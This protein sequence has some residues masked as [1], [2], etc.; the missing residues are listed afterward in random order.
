MKFVKTVVISLLLL[1]VFSGCKE[2]SWK[3]YINNN[4]EKVAR[5]VFY[6]NT[7]LL[8]KNTMEIT[9]NPNETAFFG[10]CF[11]KSDCYSLFSWIHVKV[12]WGDELAY[13][14]VPEEN[15]LH[16]SSILS[17][18]YYA[19]IDKEVKYSE[20]V[21]DLFRWC[22]DVLCENQ[23]YRDPPETDDDVFSGDS[24][25]LLWSSVARAH[26]TRKSALRYCEDLDEA[27]FQDWRL[28]SISELRTLIQNCPYMEY[29]KPAGLKDNE[30]CGVTDSCLMPDE[31]CD[32]A[33]RSCPYD[34][35]TP[36][37]Y[38]KFGDTEIFWTSSTP[39]ESS[40]SGD[41]GW[42]LGF[43]PP[44][45]IIQVEDLGSNRVRCVRDILS[46]EDIENCGDGTV[47]EGEVCDGGTIGC[48]EL[49]PE[50]VYG[51]AKC[52]SHCLGWDVKECVWQDPDTGFIWSTARGS[53]RHNEAE[54][55]CE[56]LEIGDMAQWK[57]PSISELRTLITGCQRTEAD[58]ECGVK[59]DCLKEECGD[60]YCAGCRYDLFRGYS[61]LGD[62]N[63]LRS[64]SF[65]ENEDR[66]F[67]AIDFGLGSVSKTSISDNGEFWAPDSEFSL[68]CV[69]TTK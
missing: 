35:E 33:C 6:E 51:E 68:R 29:P 21:A 65:V 60:I 3:Y 64:S 15:D 27:G 41:E 63:R 9:I 1:S 36:G 17:M 43:N 20:R 62:I 8:D 48:S 59:D 14:C 69:M 23:C 46:G 2:K 13:E 5:V 28:P 52:L 39:W 53:S 40:Y 16:S 66:F 42:R 37:K 26:L 58:G 38:S 34:R 61:K 18:W 25:N 7:A 31:S 10:E 24:K 12:F 49:S 30:W 4:S 47:D 44:K 56:N 32:A 11:Y 50:F 67:W 54:E 57:L 19:P 22:G 55:Y 45:F